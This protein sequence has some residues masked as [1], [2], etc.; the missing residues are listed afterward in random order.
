M[1]LTFCLRVA[2]EQSKVIIFGSY[3]LQKGVQNLH[4]KHAESQFLS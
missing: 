2:K 4:T 3:Y 1:W